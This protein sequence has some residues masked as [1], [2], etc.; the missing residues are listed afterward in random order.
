M[1]LLNME[2]MFLFLVVPVDR[3][4]SDDQAVT[5]SD[6]GEVFHIREKIV[7]KISTLSPRS[8]YNN[9]LAPDFN[10]CYLD[11]RK[12]GHWT[13]KILVAKNLDQILTTMHFILRYLLFN[14]I[15]ALQINKTKI[16]SYPRKTPI[17]S[18]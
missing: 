5:N 9:N 6:F 13:M 12:S 11:R 18:E 7:T 14:Q 17:S 1:V 4:F 16:Q 8:V 15:S 2:I 10:E 3:K